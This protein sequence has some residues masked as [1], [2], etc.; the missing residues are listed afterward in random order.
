MEGDYGGRRVKT[1]VYAS[2]A[3]IR[4]RVVFLSVSA[5][6]E[7]GARPAYGPRDASREPKAECVQVRL[8]S[9]RT[10]S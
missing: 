10:L 9:P 6:K 7:R 3:P 2:P 8:A 1:C 4:E 5:K